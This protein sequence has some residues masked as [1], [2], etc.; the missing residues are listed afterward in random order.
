MLCWSVGEDTCSGETF[1]A[2]CSDDGVIE[3]QNARYGRMS[4]GRCV[5][6]NLGYIGCYQDVLSYMD[7]MCSNRQSCSVDVPNDELAESDQCSELKPY[8]ETTYSCKGNH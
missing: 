3:M 6:V 8:L 4:L 1:S 7:R 2:N 5:E